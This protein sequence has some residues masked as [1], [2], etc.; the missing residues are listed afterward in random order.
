VPL[1]GVSL[2]VEPVGAVDGVEAD[3]PIE[4]D[5][6]EPLEPKLLVDE[7]PLPKLLVLL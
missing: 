6:V 3:P 4:L 1:V 2:D 7:V 5:E